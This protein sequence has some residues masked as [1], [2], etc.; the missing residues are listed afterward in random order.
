MLVCWYCL[1]SL[2]LT[3]RTTT[4][5]KFLLK[6]GRYCKQTFDGSCTF[7]ATTRGDGIILCSAFFS[8]TA[9]ITISANK[10]QTQLEHHE[11]T[12]NHTSLANAELDENTVQHFFCH[13]VS[14]DL[15]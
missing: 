8:V 4:T 2:P 9:H 12:S 13:I 6:Q 7:N 10:G 3:L 15:A 5:V 1:A 11:R 14:S